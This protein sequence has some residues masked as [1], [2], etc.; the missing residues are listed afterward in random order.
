MV[1]FRLW[2]K[3]ERKNK[4]RD[5]TKHRSLRTKALQHT[6]SIYIYIYVYLFIY[7]DTW[8]FRENR[9]Y[10]KSLKLFQGVAGWRRASAAIL[11][12]FAPCGPALGRSWKTTASLCVSWRSEKRPTHHLFVPIFQDMRTKRS[13]WYHPHCEHRLC[14]QNFGSLPEG[15]PKPEGFNATWQPLGSNKWH[16]NKTINHHKYDIY[17]I[18]WCII[19]YNINYVP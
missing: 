17:M 3:Y 10:F 11:K 12:T 6:C 1:A 18:L 7:L 15:F 4:S 19:L 14:T 13:F 16:C 9:K 2:D 8:N 5:C